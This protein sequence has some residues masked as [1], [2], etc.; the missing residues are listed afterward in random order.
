MPIGLLIVEIG[1]QVAIAV[2]TH[3][4]IRGAEEAAEKAKE[5]LGK[6]KLK[7]K[8]RWWRRY[9]ASAVSFEEKT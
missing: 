3:V 4:G 7:K 1:K 8:K 5:G 6:I 9:L 2:G